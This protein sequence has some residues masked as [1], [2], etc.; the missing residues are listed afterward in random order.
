MVVIVD[1]VLVVTGC[2]EVEL[3]ED[4]YLGVVVFEDFVEVVVDFVVAVVVV[5]VV[6]AFVV[7]VDLV[8]VDAFVV[9][10]PFVVVEKGI[11]VVVKYPE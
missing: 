5:V 4:V 3:V 11:R 6:V 1:I 8:V 7:V 10:V 2:E 9:G